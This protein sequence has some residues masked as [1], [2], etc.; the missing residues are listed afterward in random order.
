M[1]GNIRRSYELKA[2]LANSFQR[3]HSPIIATGW[4]L[5]MASY[6]YI[7]TTAWPVVRNGWQTIHSHS[8]I[9]RPTATDAGFGG[10]RPGT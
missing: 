9:S 6:V 3:T 10:I 8:G 1:F 5:G 7:D 4:E 2:Q